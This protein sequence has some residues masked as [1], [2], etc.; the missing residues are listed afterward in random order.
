M[1]AREGVERAH[2]HPARAELSI[3]VAVEPADVNARVRQAKHLHV[4]YLRKR[5][6]QKRPLC[7][8][9]AGPV[10]HLLSGPH[11]G[12]AREHVR[13]WL[14]HVLQNLLAHHTLQKAV[15]VVEVVLLD[16]I[17]ALDEG[18]VVAAV[19]LGVHWKRALLQI[20]VALNVQG[21]VVV[22]LVGWEILLHSLG[23]EYELVA[24]IVDWAAWG[25]GH[26]PV[27]GTSAF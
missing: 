14:P 27:M 12:A 20:Q 15:Q 22:L 5:G 17:L 4:E 19:V 18:R 3:R 25:C 2:L 13:E 9:V 6:A 16:A 1:V 7:Y 21:E 23:V 11:E 24:C 10:L 8:I 26:C